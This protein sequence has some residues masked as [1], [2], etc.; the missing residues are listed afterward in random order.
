MSQ[1]ARHSRREFYFDVAMLPLRE[2]LAIEAPRRASMAKSSYARTATTGTIA[3][4]YMPSL[5]VV[6]PYT[7][8]LACRACAAAP[9]T[10]TQP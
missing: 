7:T 5:A 3:P 9:A 1:T 2:L 8:D 6:T 4:G 10:R